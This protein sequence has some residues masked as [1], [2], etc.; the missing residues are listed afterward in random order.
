M[1]LDS[2][3]YCQTNTTNWTLELR[4][5]DEYYEPDLRIEVSFWTN[6]I[7]WTLE[8][9]VPDEYYEP[10]FRIEVSGRR[11]VNFV[12]NRNSFNASS[13]PFVGFQTN[14]MNQTLEFR[15]PD[16]YYKPDFRIE[17]SGGGFLNEYYELDFRIKASCWQDESGPTQDSVRGGLRGLSES[18]L[19]I[20][21][22]L[23]DF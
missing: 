3:N 21:G 8:F 19:G 17:V 2:R 22:M 14:N 4:V 12:I 10:D 20:L 15:V 13:F 9:R 23:P 7:N 18:G 6:N 16:E 5:P 1:K 11:E